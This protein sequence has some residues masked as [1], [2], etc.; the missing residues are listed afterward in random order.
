MMPVDEPPRT[1][2]YAEYKN[3]KYVLG[4]PDE[5]LHNPVLFTNMTFLRCVSTFGSGPESV[6]VFEVA[7]NA[8]G[9]QPQ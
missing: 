2:S 3:V 6:Q 8:G 5:R 9:S 4:G 7:H 1:R